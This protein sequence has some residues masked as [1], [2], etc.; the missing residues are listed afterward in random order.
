MSMITVLRRLSDSDLTRLLHDPELV[1]DYLDEQSSDEFGPFTE[2]DI[3]KAWH[4]I[5]FLLTGTECEGD[6][7]LDFLVR[8]G[9]A[10]GD[11]NIGY[12]PA[13]GWTSGEVSRLANAVR[14]LD[15][16]ELRHRFDP[17]TMTRLDI[18]PT[19]WNRDPKDEDTLGYLIGHYEALRAFIIDAA[20]AGQA[21]LVCLM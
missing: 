5:H 9:T 14:D 17:P 13:R 18:Y 16:S 6:P 12:G 21:L 3:D 11:V 20:G 1:R 19:I 7:P 2:L 4:G 15:A 10:V 8:G